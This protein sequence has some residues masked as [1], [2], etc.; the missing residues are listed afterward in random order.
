MLSLREENDLL[1][2]K[3]AEIQVANELVQ[4]QAREESK[5]QA[6]KISQLKAKSRQSNSI[7]KDMVSKVSCAMQKMIVT[8]GLLYHKRLEHKIKSQTLLA[9]L[10]HKRE[11]LY[12]AIKNNNMLSAQL[13]VE[14][15]D[16]V[17]LHHKLDSTREGDEPQQNKH[18]G[19]DDRITTTHS[20]VLIQKVHRGR[21]YRS[22]FQ[23]YK[24]SASKI[25]NSIRCS[26]AWRQLV[27]SAVMIQKV[28]HSR[29]YHSMAQRCN[30]SA[31]MIQQSF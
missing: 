15:K 4:Q 26:V 10:Q 19:N 22:K 18:A 11:E 1:K 8:K 14:G 21:M 29:M 3:I 25:Q 7:I 2:N 28:H 27:K 30:A 24:A 6:S 31:S 5:V 23:R 13:E 9:E 12:D 17:H 20:A 16:N